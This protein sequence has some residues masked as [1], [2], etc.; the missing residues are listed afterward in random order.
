MEIDQKTARYIWDAADE[1]L[2][3]M[4]KT[5][6]F[7]DEIA[8]RTLAIIRRTLITF[9]L[10]A[11][12][13]LLI[14]VFFTDRIQSVVAN[15]VDMYTRF[16]DMS[17]NMRVMTSSVTNMEQSIQGIPE[18]T[19]SMGSL[20]TNV[21]AMQRDVGSMTN[22]VVEMDRNM[23][24]IS[25]GVHQMA[26]RFGHLTDTVHGMRYNVNQM[27]QPIRDISPWPMPFP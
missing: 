3:K 25:G 10:V 1:F 2:D 22:N 19:A 4:Q 7:G 12:V 17:R 13:N 15:M 16:G 9:G 24:V 23:T 6:D 14:L 8:A 5:R 20:T 21:T 26:D 11:V 27:S 18:I